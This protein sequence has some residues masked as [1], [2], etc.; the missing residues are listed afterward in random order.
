MRALAGPDSLPWELLLLPVE[1]SGTQQR[2]SGVPHLSR[3]EKH[4]CQGLQVLENHPLLCKARVEEG[5]EL[6]TGV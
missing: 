3:T 6:C 5:T 1:V 2:P 4:E